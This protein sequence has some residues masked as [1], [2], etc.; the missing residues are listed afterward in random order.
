VSEPLPELLRLIVAVE[1][2]TSPR[3][4]K[5]PA[6]LI[7]DWLSLVA[8]AEESTRVVDVRGTAEEILAPEAYL[9]QLAR[10]QTFGP[11]LC[12]PPTQYA[13]GKTLSE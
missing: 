6:K 11:A 1:F 3:T 2:A 9:D 13:V 7:P 4:L 10:F 8:A 5:F 12:T